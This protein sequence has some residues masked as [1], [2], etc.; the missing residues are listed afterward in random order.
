MNDDPNEPHEV[1]KPAE[2]P[3]QAMPDPAGPPEPVEA[4]DGVLRGLSVAG[5]VLVAA[6]GLLLPMVASTNTTMGAM[7]STKIQW[8]QRE[9][10]V[11]RA[12]T[13]A[14]NPAAADNQ[15]GGS[16]PGVGDRGGN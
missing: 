12:L 11:R 3:T 1:T 16:A 10:E 13:E 9:A 15:S 4:D 14:Q 6:G 2:P 7:R 8:E 5:V